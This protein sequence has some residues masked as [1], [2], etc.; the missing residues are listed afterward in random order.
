MG[1]GAIKQKILF[2][3][4]VF[5]ILASS[6][7]IIYLLYVHYNEV[8]LQLTRIRQKL[9]TLFWSQFLAGRE[10]NFGWQRG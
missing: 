2:N 4:V 1:K 9:D 5:H 6:S 8:N 10:A 3:V 7:F